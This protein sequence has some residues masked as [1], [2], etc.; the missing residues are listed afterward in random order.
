MGGWLLDRPHHWH[1]HKPVGFTALRATL[2]GFWGQRCFL[3]G[4][5]GCW[6]PSLELTERGPH[7]EPGLGLAFVVKQGDCSCDSRQ[8]LGTWLVLRCSSLIAPAE[9]HFR[10]HSKGLS[11]AASCF[12]GT[13]GSAFATEQAVARPL[14]STVGPSG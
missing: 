11:I 3:F 10:F 9:G 14:G 7:G 6:Q 13:L 8:P 12:K 5:R 2:E 1:V 4:L